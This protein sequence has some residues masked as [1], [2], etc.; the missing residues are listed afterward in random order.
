MLTRSY[1]RDPASDAARAIAFAIDGAE[2]ALGLDLRELPTS[3]R[4]IAV[5]QASVRNPRA[6]DASTYALLYTLA[7]AAAPAT[8][9]ADRARVDQ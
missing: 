3:A 6:I 9:T 4:I 7:D 8:E 5:L 1:P 2:R